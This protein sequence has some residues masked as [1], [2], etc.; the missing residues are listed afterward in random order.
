M[1]I[2]GKECFIF[3]STVKIGN[4]EPFSSKLGIIQNPW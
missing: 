1:M 4:I 3:E 2:L